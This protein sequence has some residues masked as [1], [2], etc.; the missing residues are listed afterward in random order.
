MIKWSKFTK[1]YYNEFKTKK[2]I[3]NNNNNLLLF[4]KNEKKEIIKFI[5]TNNFNIKINKIDNFDNLILEHANKYFVSYVKVKNSLSK[6]LYNYLI[7]WDN[8]KIYLKSNNL[9]IIYRIT[10]I[11]Y[12]IEYLK[13][14]SNNKKKINIFLIL[15]NLKKKYP[16]NEIIGVDHVNTGYTDNT[17][18][19]FIWRNEECE[20][21]LFHEISHYFNIDR[22]KENINL[23]LNINTH[24]N[25]NESIADFYGIIY[26][27]I[28]LSILTD[29]PIKLLLEIELGFIR[30]QCMVINN[31]FG[32]T[33][34]K[35]QIPKQINQN[36]SAFSYYI[37]KYL[38]F[39]YLI[40]K[41]L[42]LNKITNLSDLFNNI[43]NYGLQTSS[44]IK[45][46]SNRMTL[47]QLY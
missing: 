8:N 30:N 6:L 47:L 7:E 25:Y 22:K 31:Y 29:N 23:N 42:V 45:I 9:N 2:Y 35:T 40:I 13:K 21:V 28:Y 36:T 1:K 4:V 12:I 3:I 11:I 27:L 43:I 41:N 15:T 32:F 19:I 20:K 24:Q 18:I 17:N 14:K 33:S 26:H 46:N 10:I 44:Y 34:W 16:I 39:N 37:L 38:L 5:K